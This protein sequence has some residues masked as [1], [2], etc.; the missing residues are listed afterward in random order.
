M[1]EA[2]DMAPSAGQGATSGADGLVR[3]LFR[4]GQFCMDRGET[5]GINRGFVERYGLCL[6]KKRTSN[7]KNCSRIV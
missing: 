5:G 6:T 7:A 4:W 1:E 2:G 3:Q